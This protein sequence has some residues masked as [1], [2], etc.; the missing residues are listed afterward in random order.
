VHLLL[1]AQGGAPGAAEPLF[2]HLRGAERRELAAL[3]DT[4]SQQAADGAAA[5]WEPVRQMA[6]P[7]SEADRGAVAAIA[8][9]D[10]RRPQRERGVRDYLRQVARY[11]FRAGRV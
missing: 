7:L 9:P 3:I 5:D 10:D 4:A 6:S 8:V 1:A 11:S 2:R